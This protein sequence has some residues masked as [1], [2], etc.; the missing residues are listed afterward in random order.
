MNI[1]IVLPRP[2]PAQHLFLSSPAK[3]RVVKAGRRGGK[4]VGVSIL[5]VQCFLTG[6]RVLYAAPTQD[7][8]SRFWASV[9]HI[10]DKA[11][12]AKVFHKNETLHIIE[13]LG[14]EQ[15]IR[16]KT[17][18]NADTLRG[19]YADVLILD[20]WQLI[21]EDAWDIVGA[22]M[23]LD[24]DGDA[25]FVFTPPSYRTAGVSKAVDKRHA[26]KM[27]DKALADTTGRWQAFHFTSYDNPHIS[28][29]ALDSLIE[30]VSEL[31]IRQEILAEDIT[32]IPGALWSLEVLERTRVRA[33]PE[34]TKIYI[35]IDPKTEETASSEA[36]IV[37]VG[38]GIDKHGYVLGD[39]SRN[40]S[41]EDWASTA[42]HAYHEL[43]ADGIVA[44][45]NQG[46]D[47]VISTLSTVEKNLPIIRVRATR[48]KYLRAEPVSVL[49]GLGKVHHVG[50]F[51]KLEDQQRSWLPGGRSP[52][53]LDALVQG[54]T[55][56]M[57]PKR[58]GWARGAG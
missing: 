53:R 35:S 42:V 27:F 26:T 25:I 5:A 21:A 17:A 18:W 3:R 34:L 13:L 32:E 37:A 48:G 33:A 51:G 36:G 49:Y 2:H 56:I 11:I 31:V 47:M 22:P 15:R 46:G 39:F 1:D 52:D 24:N 19:D 7:Q 4:T 23:L 45:I 38:L 28:R 58:S 55:A 20:E 6:K 16:A 10:L 57:I 29:I 30:D 9:T 12:T 40:G 41:P 44:E 8:L 43:N 54:I 14:T 50:M